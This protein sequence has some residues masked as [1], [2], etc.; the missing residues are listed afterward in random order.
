MARNYAGIH[1]SMLERLILSCH[2]CAHESKGAFVRSDVHDYPWISR[3]PKKKYVFPAPK[4]LQTAVVCH[5]GYTGSA[6]IGP[7]IP[8][9]VQI[10][11]C[12]VQTSLIN[13]GVYLLACPRTRLFVQG[14]VKTENL[15][16]LLVAHG[17]GIRT[18]EIATSSV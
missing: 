11:L 16:V 3:Q 17:K 14:K 18:N 12:S 1:G 15:H 13:A 10:F 6:A 8:T 2:L 5:F 4:Y 7:S 9:N